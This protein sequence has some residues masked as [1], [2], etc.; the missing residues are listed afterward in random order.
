MD[1]DV[2]LE[3]SS[4]ACQAGRGT[5]PAMTTEVRC[6]DWKRLVT[7]RRNGRARLIGRRM[8][9]GRER[10]VLDAGRHAGCRCGL[11]W[12]GSCRRRSVVNLYPARPW[13]RN[14]CESHLQPRL[15]P[16]AAHR[17]S[18]F[19]TC[20]LARRQCVLRRCVT[21]AS[22]SVGVGV[23]GRHGTWRVRCTSVGD[24]LHGSGRDLHELRVECYWRGWRGWYEYCGYDRLDG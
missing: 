21:A 22:A 11:V 8:R 10:R 16:F 13:Q 12:H 14:I 24:K 5:W 1:P 7:C 2:G 4:L 3:G 19:R 18:S 9:G 20:Q 15:E 17:T 23:R 6:Q